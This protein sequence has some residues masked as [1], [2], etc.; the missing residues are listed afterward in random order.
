MNIRKYLMAM[1]IGLLASNANA[2]TIHVF[3]LWDNTSNETV[4]EEMYFEDNGVTM[5]VSAW[6][7]SFDSSQQ[8]L[9]DWNK[10]SGSDVGVYRDENGLGV[11]SSQGDGNDLD[12]GSSSNFAD[13]PDEGL[14][15]TFSHEVN[16][17]DLFVGDLDYND[18]FNFSLVDLTNPDTPVLVASDID[19]SGPEFETEWPFLFS[20]GFTGS[21][22]MVWVDGGSDDIELLGVAVQKVPVPATVYLM[23]AGLAGLAYRRRK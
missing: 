11:I 16:I 18:D 15:L 19:I 22:F 10:V 6:T 21:A 14:L 12:G 17:L 3:P 2:S 20:H 1:A 9:E 13:D 7:T 5:T 23:L 8:Q 4:S